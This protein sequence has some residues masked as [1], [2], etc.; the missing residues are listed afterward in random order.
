MFVCTGLAKCGY[1]LCSGHYMAANPKW[2]QPLETWKQYYHKWVGYPEYDQLLHITVFLEVRTLYGDPSLSEQ[3]QSYL[4]Q[5][6]Q[7]NH[8]FLSSLTESAILN[9]PPLGIF[10][11]FVL[12]KTGENTKELNVKK[13]ALNL[14]VDLARIYSLSVGSEAMETEDRFKAAFEANVLKEETYLNIIGAYQFLMQVRLDHQLKALKN[15]DEP[16]NHIAPERF[17]SF[18]GKHLKEAFKIISD[19]QNFAKLYFG[20]H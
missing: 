14:I 8:Q 4:Y 13:Y 19:T 1:S 5:Q 12:E 2:C 7:A 17:S 6:I 15:G 3:L 9:N 18:K 16:N 20:R 11:N 10:K